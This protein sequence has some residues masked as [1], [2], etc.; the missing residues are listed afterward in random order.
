MGTRITPCTSFVP[1]TTA[2]A[3]CA[4][5]LFTALTVLV[6]LVALSLTPPIFFTA[7]FVGLI[8]GLVRRDLRRFGAGRESE[9]IW[10]ILPFAVLPW[11]VYLALPVSMHLKKYL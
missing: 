8:S 2:C 5:I 4:V 1:S 6:R 7:A 9:F 11:V 3:A 10:F